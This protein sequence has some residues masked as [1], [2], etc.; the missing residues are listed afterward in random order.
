MCIHAPN[1]T[2]ARELSSPV[3]RV[4][5]GTEIVTQDQQVDETVRKEVIDEDEVDGTSGQPAG[6]T[7]NKKR[8]R[9]LIRRKIMTIHDDGATRATNPNSARATAPV[10]EHPE[11]PQ[12]RTTEH[13]AERSQD[14]RDRV[15]WGPVWAGVLAVLTV[16]IVLQL[17]FFALGWLDLGFNGADGT[18]ATAGIVT[19]VLALIAFFVGGLLA[20]ASTL[21]R[22]AGDGLLHGV[23]VWALSVLGI[24]ALALIGGSALLGPLAQLVGQAAQ[25]GVQAPDVQVDPAQALEAARQTAGSTALG[26]GL[27]VA[28]AAIGGTVGSKLWPGKNKSNGVA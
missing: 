26:L 3:E 16:F 28:A 2:E 14:R 25:S 11:H 7:A 21:W 20:G 4:R 22:G 27:A 15:R 6:R 24:L 17:L 18:G 13:V 12:D 8:N 1:T 10:I 23:L 19:G 5:L 9:R